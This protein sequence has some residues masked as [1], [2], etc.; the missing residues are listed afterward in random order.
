MSHR[1]STAEHAR[2]PWSRECG[3]VAQPRA[4]QHKAIIMSTNRLAGSVKMEPR[5]KTTP[6]MP[7][8]WKAGAEIDVL[9]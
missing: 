2:T 9:D 1:R 7:A 8:C 5:A 6:M 4:G 3:G